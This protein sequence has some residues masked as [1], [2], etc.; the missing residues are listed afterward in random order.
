MEKVKTA[1]A[2]LKSALAGGD[3]E[4]VKAKHEE[5]AKASQD[6]G[7]ALYAQASEASAG[8]EG[9]GAESSSRRNDDDDVVDAEIV[10]EDK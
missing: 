1:V 2:D 7:S 3:I 4:A 10:D 5:L 9:S 8:A 6:L